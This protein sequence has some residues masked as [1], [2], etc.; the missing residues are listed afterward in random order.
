MDESEYW[1]HF[2]FVPEPATLLS[3]RSVVGI[4]A[5]TEAFF[6]EYAANP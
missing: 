1:R 3:A 4:G 5:R 2:D 6:G